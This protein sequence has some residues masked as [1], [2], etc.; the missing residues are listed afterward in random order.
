MMISIIV[1]SVTTCGTVATGAV[2]GQFLATTAGARVRKS[3]SGQIAS[4]VKTAEKCQP[5][6]RSN[7]ASLKVVVPAKS[8]TVWAP[9]A[10]S[11]A[12]E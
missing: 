3:A 10:A 11:A 9:S 12:T 5:S 4:R 1:M 8:Y 2:V 6:P 7:G